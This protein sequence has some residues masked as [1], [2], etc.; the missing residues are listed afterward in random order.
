MNWQQEGARGLLSA[1]ERQPAC[2]YLKWEDPSAAQGLADWLEETL[3]GGRQALS[4]VAAPSALHADPTSA[5]AHVVEM[6]RRCKPA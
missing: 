6:E 2:F 5:L 1:P 3:H 4:H